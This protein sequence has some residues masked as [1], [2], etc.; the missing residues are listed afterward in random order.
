MG[1]NVIASI[2]PATTGG[3]FAFEA[4]GVSGDQLLTSPAYILQ[5]YIIDNAVGSM[6][7][8][9]AGNAWPLYV[10]Y[11]PDNDDTKTNLGVLYDTTPIKEGRLMEG[12]IVSPFGIQLKIRTQ[13]HI[14]GYTKAEE[15]ANTLD[16]VQNNIITID[17]N[18]YL[19]ENISRLGAPVS[20][21]IEKGTKERRLFTVNFILTMKRIT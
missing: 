21:G 11:T 15:I 14:E 1:Y 6:T 20:L 7:D 2:T 4:I 18:D 16:A 8:P 13:K 19:I 3:L 17:A 10:S 12:Q 9:S 5:Q